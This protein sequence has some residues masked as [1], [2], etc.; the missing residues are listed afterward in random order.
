M[1]EDTSLKFAFG[2]KVSDTEPKYEN[3]SK[4]GVA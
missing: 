4:G 3:R 1:A 2:L